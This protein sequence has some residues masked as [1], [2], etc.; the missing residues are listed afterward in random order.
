MI[1]KWRECRQ[2]TKL[3]IIAVVQVRGDGDLNYSGDSESGGKWP[4]SSCDLKTRL[5]WCATRSDKGYEGKR[6]VRAGRQVSGLSALMTEVFSDM[7]EM[8]TQVV[9]SS[10]F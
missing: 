1:T 4:D 2:K 9:Y 10:Q 7:S 3:K 8:R 6:S 5:L